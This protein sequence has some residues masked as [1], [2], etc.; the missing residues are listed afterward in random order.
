[1]TTQVKAVDDILTTLHDDTDE[2]LDDTDDP[3]GKTYSVRVIF[4]FAI[5]FA[6]ASATRNGLNH[7]LR[8]FLSVL[9][10]IAIQTSAP[11]SWLVFRLQNPI[12]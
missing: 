11:S 8:F 6:S 3:Y 4:C 10:I 1:M 2:L 5:A 7:F 9:P 12:L